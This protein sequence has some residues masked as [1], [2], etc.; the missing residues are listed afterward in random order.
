MLLF[1]RSPDYQPS[2][3]TKKGLP[4]IRLSSINPFLHELQRRGVDAGAL[5]REYELPG[6]VPASGE[7]FVSA[8]TMYSLIE[9]CAEVANDPYLG[10]RIGKQLVLHNWEP[11][12][13]AACDA[14]SLGSLLA[15]FIVRVVDHSSSAHF[16]LRTEGIWSIFGFERATTP[17]VTPSQGDAFY[18]GFV[19]QLLIRTMGNQWDSTKVLFKVANPDVVPTGPERL[20]V[21]PGDHKGMQAR[22]PTEWQFEPFQGLN[23]KASTMIAAGYPPDSMIDAVKVALLPHIHE[24]DLTVERA[25]SICGIEQ[26][27]LARALSEQGTSTVK[28]ISALRRERATDELINTNRKVSDVAAMVGFKDPAVFSRAF[29]N[30]TGKSP[31]HYRR[32]HH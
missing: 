19:S 11:I 24:P 29:K 13:K 7:L 16:F 14:D 31:Q 21:V 1:F 27:R 8:A 12:A 20:R 17:P 23:T 25:A 3:M 4:L 10:F 5:L 2:K 28:L 26:R 18:V 6:R 9:R 30:W 22:F 32:A 15:H